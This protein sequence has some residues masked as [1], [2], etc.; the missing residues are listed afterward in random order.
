MA[1]DRAVGLPQVALERGSRMKQGLTRL[2]VATSPELTQMKPGW[3]S[4]TWTHH[5]SQKAARTG[6]PVQGHLGAG[7]G[8]VVEC[9]YSGYPDTGRLCKMVVRIHLDE[10]RD[11]VLVLVPRGGQGDFVVVT[12]WANFK[13]DR[14]STL[15][16]TR[17]GRFG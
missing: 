15:D 5:A 13:A 14:H 10:Q 4:L 1:E 6:V 7:A 11:Q 17:L 16:R 12:C 9:E 2:N 8:S 3:L